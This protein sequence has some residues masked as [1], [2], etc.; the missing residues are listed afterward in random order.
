MS[1]NRTIAGLIGFCMAAAMPAQLP[2]E[3]LWQSTRGGSA[4]DF[5]EDIQLTADGGYIVGGG[6]ASGNGDVTGPHGHFDAW[7]VR[8]DPNGGLLWQRTLGGTGEDYC[9]SIQQ[10]P[11]SGF[12]F[13]GETHS[14]NGDVS[15]NH[16]F[17]DVWV[18]KLD[19]SGDM[20]WQ[21]PYGGSGNDYGNDIRNTPDGGY[22]FTGYTASNNGDVGTYLG[23]YDMWV[24]KLDSAG[25]IEWEHSYGGSDGD[26]GQAIEQTV[27]GGYVVTGATRSNDGDVTGQHGEKDFWTIKIDGLGALQ[28][29]STL[30]GSDY[31]V[32]YG[33]E[34][35][36]DGGYVAAGST[37]SI[38]GDVVGNHGWS[39]DYWV[40]KYD[41]TG[42]VVWQSTLGGSGTEIAHDISVTPDGGYLLVG[43]GDSFDG[44]KPDSLGLTDCWVVKLD[45][46]GA[47]QWQKTMGGSGIDA[48]RSVIVLD[49]LTYVAGGLS[50]SNDYDVTG[51]HGSNDFWV[52]KLGPLSTSLEQLDRPSFR[53]YP[54]PAHDR[55]M[56]HIPDDDP[57]A[58][59]EVIDVTG[60]IVSRVGGPV[61]ASI[62]ID[63]Y[64]FGK[65]VYVVRLTKREGSF[66]QRLVVQ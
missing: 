57:S 24:V 61:D 2:P 35:S 48:F 8:L 20:E 51:G 45:D 40:V 54:N 3:L 17:V 43:M 7:I 59:I 32:A 18:V 39:T 25:Q 9:R 58:T 56:I 52:V 1:F 65:G 23:V 37:G 4:S 12:I 11:D 36:P 53:V 55:V 27:D 29:Q 47:L 15:G 16:G 30:G 14:N 34:L 42:A 21:H 41:D 60:Q 5:A 31:E 26:Q 13:I 64:G 62:T 28:W 33:L 22:V 49:S 66:S 6:S 46:A 63:L 50:S 10:T 38:D 44:D 19:A